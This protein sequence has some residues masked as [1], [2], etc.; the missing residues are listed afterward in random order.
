MSQLLQ[1]CGLLPNS[2]QV[3]SV[4]MLHKQASFWML[5]WQVA[6]VCLWMWR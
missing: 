6:K 1:R 4:A 5:Q 3:S 2:A